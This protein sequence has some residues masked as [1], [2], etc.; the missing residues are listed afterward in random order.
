LAIIAVFLGWAPRG[1]AESLDDIKGLSVVVSWRQEET[2]YNEFGARFRLPKDR[3]ITLY[4]SSKGNVFEYPAE[5]NRW[6][7][8][9]TVYTVDK[10][11][12][13]SSGHWGQG[14]MMVWA[15]MDG[16]LA[17]I[18]KGVQ[19]FGVLTVAID[20]AR[21]SCTFDAQ[22][23][24]DPQTGMYATDLTGPVIQLEA[25]KVTSY[26]CSVKRGNIFASASE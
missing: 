5:S 1:D 10:A 12:T 25:V 14:Q 15:M 16:H 19:G 21:L 2:G 9:P 8:G 26:S 18:A 4:I 24:P 23:K 11:T 6:R 7:Y 17:Q 22:V 20:P 13:W 3:S